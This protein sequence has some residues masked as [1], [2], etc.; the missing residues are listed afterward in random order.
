MTSKLIWL[1]N[2]LENVECLITHTKKMKN[3]LNLTKLKT[4]NTKKG[5]LMEKYCNYFMELD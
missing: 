1:L 4:V 2:I 3:K 5:L